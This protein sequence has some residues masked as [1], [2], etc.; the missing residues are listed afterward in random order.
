MNSGVKEEQEIIKKIDCTCVEFSK[1]KSFSLQWSVG[2][3]SFERERGENPKSYQ[4]SNWDGQ[5]ARA[6]PSKELFEKNNLETK[7]R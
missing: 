1:W 5:S 4:L 3:L 7:E 2:L 6:R